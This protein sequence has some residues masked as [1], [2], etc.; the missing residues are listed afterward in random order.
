[1]NEEAQFCLEETKENMENAV[2]HLER[3][4]HKIR[5]GK[6]SPQMLDNIRVDYYGNST[7][8]SQISNINTPNPRTIVIQPW[9]KNM[10]SPI[11]KA[12]LTANLGFNPQNDGT[13]IRITVPPLTEER[14]KQLV[15]QVKTEGETSKISIRNSRRIG[16]ETIKEL[17]K[18]TITEDESKK[19]QDEIQKFTNS[20]IE[21]I[22]KI[23]EDKE[24]EIMTV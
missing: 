22:D 4:L 14:R 19:S 1:M 18:N 5:A 24:K 10:I 2:S 21:K 7:P 20:F 15:K 16:K 17:E 3:E 8:L 9:E 6:A 11:E 23:I 12:I 13:L